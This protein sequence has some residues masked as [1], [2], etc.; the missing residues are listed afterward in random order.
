VLT[1]KRP[2]LLDRTLGSFFEANKRKI[3]I[4]YFLILNQDADPETRAVIDKYKK[5]WPN[6]FA[7]V[8]DIVPNVGSSCGYSMLMCEALRAPVPYILFLED[9]WESKQPLVD[10]IDEILKF[11][12]DRKDVGFIRLRDASNR[13]WRKHSVTREP[14]IYTPATEHIL[15]G[16]AHFTFNPT[17]T[18]S[19]I[20]R[21]II[22][23]YKERQAV[24]NYHEKIGLL[25]SQ[26]NAKCFVDISVSAG[27]RDNPGWT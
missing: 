5:E 2:E 10:Y 1:F 12:D 22:P 7:R 14:I 8:I 21:D 11:L 27:M 19:N 25:S 6:S 4:F 18:R 23:V 9:D 26:L 16:N 13:V 17:I 20:I 15:V 3:N 24:V